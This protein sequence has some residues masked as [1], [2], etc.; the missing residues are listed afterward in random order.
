MINDV[1]SSEQF[2]F[3]IEK[4]RIEKKNTIQ[5]LTNGIISRRSYTRF[6]S[7]E[8]DI[9]FDILVKLIDRLGYAIFDFGLYVYNHNIQTNLDEVMFMEMIKLS[10][11]EIAFNEFYPLIKDKKWKS[12]FATKAIPCAV[13]MMNLHFKKI[14]QV[15]AYGLIKDILQIDEIIQSPI[16]YKEDIESLYICMDILKRMD[17]FKISQYLYKTL[18]NNVKIVS[19]SIDNTTMLTYLTLV[20]SLSLDSIIEATDHVMIKEVIIKAI[21]YLY[22]SKTAIMDIVFF[23]TIL[24]YC[25]SN[26]FYYEEVVFAYISTL[27]SSPENYYTYGKTIIL[28]DEDVKTFTRLLTNTAFINSDIYSRIIYD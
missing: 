12:I 4:I 5:E 8:T 23:E 10:Q 15:E 1:F 17:R 13:I 20:K 14:R 2:I 3:Y 11:Y 26:S 27:I 7:N 28:S 22:K 16:I 18:S 25:R 19:P 9:S 6:L 21:A 24:E